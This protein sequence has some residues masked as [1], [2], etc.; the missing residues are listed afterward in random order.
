M[1]N[2]H[3]I[4]IISTGYY[5]PGDPVPNRD[6]IK[7]ISTTDEWIVEN[8]GIKERYISSQG[9]NSSYLGG[10]A[11]IQA[12]GNSGLHS[13]DI[14]LLI[15]AT[16]TPDKLSPSTACIIKGELGL[17]KAIAFDIS[18]VCSGF[19]F[20]MSVAAQYISSGMVD[21]AVVVGVDVF[22]TITDWNRRDCI[23][24]G[25]GAGAV[26]M[27]KSEERGF[28]GFTLYS[29]SIDR[30]GFYC[31]HGEKFNMIGRSVYDTALRV[32]PIAIN[33]VLEKN[34]MTLEQVD[35]IIPHQPSRRILVDLAKVLGVPEEK[36]LMNMDKYAN[37]VAGTIPILLH[38]TW[39][40]L[41]KGDIVLFAAI[42]SGWTYG[43][44]LYKV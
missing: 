26:V 22:S 37:T 10:I 11:A 3:N 19:L 43:A 17:V 20:G 7:N 33:G 31:N 27:Q 23:F 18:A 5:V 28:I 44:G 15:V 40:K 42:G 25:D 36:V 38:E 1:K 34:N 32:L 9:E 35:Y 30:V 6:I 8:T 29:D 12:I 16:A 21:N 14:D 41:K 24:F 39:P 4:K 13:Y 2:K